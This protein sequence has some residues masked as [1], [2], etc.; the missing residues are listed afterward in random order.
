MKKR[1]ELGD[2]KTVG[3]S[4]WVGK[5]H[6]SKDVAR[7]VLGKRRRSWLLRVAGADRDKIFLV[8]VSFRSLPNTEFEMLLE[9]IAG[10][11][12]LGSDFDVDTRRRGVMFSFQRRD[13]A[14]AAA[15][16]LSTGTRQRIGLRVEVHGKVWP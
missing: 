14:V 4:E 2:I 11:K 10:R 12:M 6:R 13:A 1:I 3:K 16:R 7:R 9:R 8:T 15:E 5:P